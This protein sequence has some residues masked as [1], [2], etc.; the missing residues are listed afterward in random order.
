MSHPNIV[1]AY[2]ADEFE[3]THFLVM[4]NVEGEDLNSHVRKRGPLPVDQAVDL[5]KQAAEGLSY[6]HAQ[7]VIHRD[8]KPPN[9]LLGTDGVLK[10]L[11][12]GLARFE[13]NNRN[14]SIML[15]QDG[16]VM[17]TVDYMSPGAGIGRA[18]RGRSS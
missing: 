13:S 1:T 3:R 12:M 6:A 7:G 8:I 9:L 17:G 18:Q 5:I 11:D 10:I 16:A 4:E 2:D 15:T 14:E